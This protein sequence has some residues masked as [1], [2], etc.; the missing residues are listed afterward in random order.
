ASWRGFPFTR[1]EQGALPARPCPTALQAG[2]RA[3]ISA[4]KSP[5]PRLA[6]ITTITDEARIALDTMAGRAAQ[7]FSPTLR[8]GISGLSR[9]GT[10]VFITALVHNPLHG[11]RLTLFEAQKSGRIARAFLEHQPDDAE[12]RFQYEDHVGVLVYV[13]I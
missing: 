5:E 13:R 6:A 4:L 10:A 9:S 12:P 3:P 2:P 1:A 7:L 11:G 8:L